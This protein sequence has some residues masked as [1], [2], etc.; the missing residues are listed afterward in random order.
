MKYNKGILLAWNLECSGGKI[1]NRYNTNVIYLE[2][3][4][5]FLTGLTY[6]VAVFWNL[7]IHLHGSY[8]S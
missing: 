4:F 2:K 3:H 7:Q 8:S 6:A 5:T 1:A